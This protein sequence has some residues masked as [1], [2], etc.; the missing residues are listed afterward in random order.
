VNGVPHH[1][2]TPRLLLRP[3]A[4]GD[5]D[6]IVTGVGNYEVAKWLGVVPYPYRITDA[7]AFLAS[8]AAAPGQT[9]AIC[10]DAGL[11]GII[12]HR[13]QLGYWLARAAWGRGYL[14][15]ACDAVTDAVFADRRRTIIHAGHFSGNE[16]SS[17]VLIKQGFV[18]TGTT[19]VEARTLAQTVTSH[20]MELSRETWAARRVYRLRTPHLTLRELRDGDLAPLMRIAGQDAVARMLFN[21]PLP[22]PEADAR[23]WLDAWR[24]R[25]RLGFRVAITRWGRMIGAIGI[26]HIPGRPTVTCMYFLDPRHWGRGYAKE[27]LVHFLNDTMARFDVQT[28]WADHFDDNPASGG[29]LRHAGFVQTHTDTGISAARGREQGIIVYRL[30]RGDLREI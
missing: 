10:D 22:W 13:D 12:S 15:E 11:Q 23:R 7:E 6:E 29:V 1:L 5:A 30:Q 27:A 16:R 4:P 17:R 2:R 8:D 9:W 3:L 24:Y 18:Y 19:G 21:I 26:G 20:N 25:G 14:T 28:V